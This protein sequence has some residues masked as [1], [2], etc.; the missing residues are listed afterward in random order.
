LVAGE[1]AAAPAAGP[2]VNGIQAFI[3][4]RLPPE[5]APGVVLRQMSS[6]RLSALTVALYLVGAVMTFGWLFVVASGPVECSG[7]SERCEWVVV[8]AGQTAL[9]WPLYWGQRMIGPR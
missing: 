6:M 4:D 8:S 3:Y 5:E 1:A 7:R 9:A 2:T